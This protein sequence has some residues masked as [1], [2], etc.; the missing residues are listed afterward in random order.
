M[1]TDVDY[2]ERFRAH[3]TPLFSDATPLQLGWHDGDTGLALALPRPL[4]IYLAELLAGLL[5]TVIADPA[6]TV[7]IDNAAALVNLHKGR[8]P[9]EWLPWVIP[10]FRDR[11]VSFRY[12]PTHLNLADGPSRA[13]LG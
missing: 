7:W 12:I 2:H 8:C 5:A 10:I 6:S 4:P 3:P 9:Q 13:P 11:R 1:F